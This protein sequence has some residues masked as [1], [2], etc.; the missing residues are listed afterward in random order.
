MNTNMAPC[1]TQTFIIK[2]SRIK[3]IVLILI[4]I[5]FYIYVKTGLEPKVYS[6]RLTSSSWETTVLFTQ[7]KLK[8]EKV[9][10]KGIGNNKT[11]IRPDWDFNL[12]V[13]IHLLSSKP[14][15]IDRKSLFL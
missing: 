6:D 9:C 7:R 1:Y 10:G 11:I 8:Q 14:I 4:F 12:F 15:K 3:L 2:K 13:S 5:L